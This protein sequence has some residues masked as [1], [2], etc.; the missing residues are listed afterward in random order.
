MV[1]FQKFPLSS[2]ET[3]FLLN[4]FQEF[5]SQISTTGQMVKAILDDLN[6]LLSNLDLAQ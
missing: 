1:Q 6:W 3:F 2:V 5:G 4:Y